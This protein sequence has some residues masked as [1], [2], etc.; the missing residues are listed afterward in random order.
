MGPEIFMSLGFLAAVIGGLV[1]SMM[2]STAVLLYGWRRRSRVS[3]SG[4]VS[5]FRD[6]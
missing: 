4:G 1:A 3:R 2:S 5:P 6:R